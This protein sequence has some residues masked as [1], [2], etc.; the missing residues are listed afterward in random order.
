M[1]FAY[2]RLT[3]MAVVYDKEG[4]KLDGIME[5]TTPFIQEYPGGD[6]TVSSTPYRYRLISSSLKL[7]FSEG[8][9]RK[10]KL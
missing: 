2:E 3:D 6:T 10:G 9:R 8:R 1:I 4:K 5:L 7:G